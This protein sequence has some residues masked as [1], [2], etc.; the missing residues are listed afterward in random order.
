MSISNL[1]TVALSR[2]RS[3]LHQK[4]HIRSW[5]QFA[6]IC[7]ALSDDHRRWVFRGQE[8]SKWPLSTTFEREANR[9]NHNAR[10]WNNLERT[11][12][13]EF[14]KGGYR[15]VQNAPGYSSTLQWL[16]M[17]QHFGAPTRL[18]D[19]TKSPYI[20]AFFALSGQVG[21]H[22]TIW[23]INRQELERV[24]SNIVSPPPGFESSWK[25]YQYT[26][27]SAE[28]ICN[29]LIDNTDPAGE[30]LILP[31][32]PTLLNERIA[33]QQGLFLMQDSLHQSFESRL[34]AFLDKLAERKIGVAD[35]RFS[36]IQRSIDDRSYKGFKNVY[37]AIWRNSD[38]D[39]F[40]V[41]SAAI[42]IEIIV[43]NKQRSEFMNNLDHMN[44]NMHSLFP[45][46]DGYAKH[47]KRFVEKW[48]SDENQT[49]AHFR[50]FFGTRR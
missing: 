33:V 34:S 49:I 36:I 27:P 20:A 41:A 5:E 16:A 40:I 9:Y 37:D 45:G 7:T 47:M 29:K 35:Q 39:R 46:L 2:I 24:L 28:A 18:L 44:I 6:K 1:N 48:S 23:A 50:T 32:E 21:S 19:F 26:S 15:Y 3:F 4:V 8:D 42:L 31:I 17:M 38:L 11:L 25:G 12:L 13:H 22:F 10:A 14:I 30:P 43:K